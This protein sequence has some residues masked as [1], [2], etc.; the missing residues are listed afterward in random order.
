MCIGAELD[1]TLVS[2]D[3]DVDPTLV[4]HDNVDSPLVCR[5]ETPLLVPSI[6]D[7]PLPR[8]NKYSLKPDIESELRDYQWELALPGLSGRNYIICAPTGSGK[9]RVAGLIIAEHLRQLQGQ[10]KVLFVVNKVPLVQQQRCAL[11]DMIQGLRIEEVAGD[12]PL[13]KKAMLSASLKDSSS[14]EEEEDDLNLEN[15]VIVCTAGCLMN[16]LSF[17]AMSL[18]SVSLMVI[19][20]CHHTRKNSAYARIMEKYIR[21][22][23]SLTKLPQ[24]IGLTATPGAGDAS[25]PTITSVIDHM[26]TLCAAMDAT[27]GIKT[28]TK[29]I[30]ELKRHQT[31]AVHTRAV[32]QGRNEDEPLFRTI[33]P[34]M[35]KLESLYKKSTPPSDNKWSLKYYSWVNSQIKECQEKAADNRDNISVMKVLKSLSLVLQVYQN[36]TYEDAMVELSKLALPSSQKATYIEQNLTKV[37]SQLKIKLDSLERF[38]NPMLLQLED[39]LEVNFQRKPDSKVIVFVE[40]KNEATSIQRWISSRPRLQAVRPDVVTGQTRDTGK[41]MTKAEQNSSL[42]GFREDSFNLLVSTSVLEEG[43]D[44][45]ACNLVIRYQ[46]VTSEIAQVQ[47][48]GRAR[49]SRSQSITIVNSDSRKQFQEI[50]NEE[51]NGLVEQALEMLP[52]AESLRLGIQTKQAAILK[53]KDRQVDMA[54]SRTKQHS[55]MEVDICCNRCSTVLCNGADIHTIPNTCHYVVTNDNILSRI[56]IRQHHNPSYRPNDLSRTH[57]LFCKHCE[58]QPLGVIGKWWKDDVQ[59]P[60]IKCQYVKFMVG[61]CVIPCKQWKNAP[62]DVSPM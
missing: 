58:V 40:T 52:A 5:G 32:L 62:F 60:V 23:L 29:H 12:T 24:V 14:S 37:I 61:N 15:D 22:K 47:S 48:S 42:E 31:S 18:S 16:Q 53:Q 11:Q 59:Y 49:A 36:L 55:P 38:E 7:Y 20:E 19:D 46:K 13:H 50:L 8:T 30:P 10:G 26:I 4:T 25:R 41:K 43:L 44:V 34:I 51:K 45:P 35:T 54:E 56:N 1:P 3:D 57:K 33:P 9:T 27:G 2:C 21:S 17:K 39:I 28:V 6:S